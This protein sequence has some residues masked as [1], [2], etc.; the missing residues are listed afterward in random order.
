MRLW[1]LNICLPGGLTFDLSSRQYLFNG[2][3]NALTLKAAPTRYTIFFLCMLRPMKC[4][5][6]GLVATVPHARNA[7]MALVNGERIWKWDEQEWAGEMAGD[8]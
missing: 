6:H 5:L 2:A 7:G 8:S 3:C 4:N 1:G